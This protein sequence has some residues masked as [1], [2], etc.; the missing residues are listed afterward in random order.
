MIGD[1]GALFC[2]NLGL[3]TVR[4][5]EIAVA[6]AARPGFSLGHDLAT[7]NFHLTVQFINIEFASASALTMAWLIG[8]TLVGASDEE[9]LDDARRRGISL[10]QIFED[11]QSRLESSLLRAWLVAAPLG[12]ILKA[13]GV[14]A[15]ILPVGGW[16]ALDAPTAVADLGGMLAAVVLWR[17]VLVRIV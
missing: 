10:Q 13:I 4:T 8:S 12:F 2:Y 3:S 6:E 14:A 16:L 17:T 1:A 5:V 15:V 11:P 7:A 9:W